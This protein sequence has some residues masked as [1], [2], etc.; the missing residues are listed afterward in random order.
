MQ[1]CVE[2]HGL[3]L[4]QLVAEATIATAPVS[5][6][7]ATIATAPVSDGQ[8][9]IATAPAS[10]VL[11]KTTA[12]TVENSWSS[13]TPMTPPTPPLP[14]PNTAGLNGIYTSI[15][16]VDEINPQANDKIDAKTAALKAVKMHADSDP[17]YPIAS[18]N[19]N[20]DEFISSI[21][22]DGGKGDTGSDEYSV[23]DGGWR[24][25]GKA[26]D[27]PMMSLDGRGIQFWWRLHCKGN[28]L[29]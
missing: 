16:G 24:A 12:A 6:G 22:V 5:D 3:E 10:D 28:R 26:G 11:G 4:R 13:I 14:P 20:G 19:P 1:C 27:G 7:Q 18:T 9:T 8:A 21:H 29:C 15:P 2:K 23:G 25:V 17:D